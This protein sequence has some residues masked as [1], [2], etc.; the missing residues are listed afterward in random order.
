VPV[1]DGHGGDPGQSRTPGTT[2]GPRDFVIF[3][4]AQFTTFSASWMQKTAIGWLVWDLTRSP[5]WVGAV[6]LSELFAAF[7]V[8]PL[9]G[10]VTDRANPYRLIQTTQSVLIANTLLL[11]GLLLMGLVTPIIL[12]AWAI[13]DACIQGFNQPVRTVVIGSLSPEGR[14]GQAIAANSVAAN[15]GRIL[16]PA[17]AGIILLN[18]EVSH[19]LTLNVILFSAMLVVVL[20]L[21]RR[22]ER[23]AL[24][25]E[26]ITLFADVR[27]GLRYIRDDPQLR[28]LF[29]L[30]L[31]FSLFARPFAELFPALAGGDFGGGPGTLSLFLMAQGVGAL[32]G[33]LWL[34]H[35]RRGT[36]LLRITCAAALGIGLVLVIFSVSTSLWLAAVTIALAGLFHV[37]CNIGMQTTAQT[38]SVPAMRGRVVAL[39]LLM[40]RAAPALGAFLLGVLAQRFGLQHLIGIAAGGFLV[41]LGLIWPRLRRT[42]AL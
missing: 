18:G 15:L 33:A 38:I 7:V 21:R 13:F 27:S 39:Y 42:F 28:I 3:A 25:N 16:G 9:S 12:V 40:F 19:V 11:S 1:S 41:A 29:A 26:G 2:G 6:A 17:L 20:L 36:A 35:P 24:P 14:T 37:V 32:A 31:A 30:V 8:G 23:P 10:A 34:L 5:A 22:I 4:V